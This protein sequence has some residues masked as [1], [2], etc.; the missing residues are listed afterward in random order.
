MPTQRQTRV[1]RRL[2]E[3]IARLLLREIEDP[4]IR[5]VTITDVEVSP[6][7]KCARVFFSVMGT[8]DP[9]ETLKGLRR[10]SR[11]IRHRLA[12]EAELRYTPTLDFRYDATAERAQRIEAILHRLAEEGSLHPPDDEEPAE[13]GSPPA[14]AEDDE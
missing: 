5:F 6:D 11:Y 10:A 4:L 12:E 9:A 2:Q 8:D 7:L 14:D 3:E 13:V 1:A